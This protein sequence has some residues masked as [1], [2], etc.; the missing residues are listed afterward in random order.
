MAAPAAPRAAAA[1]APISQRPPPSQTRSAAIPA[2]A[3]PAL[4]PLDTVLAI[5]AA[6]VGLIAIGT[7]LW[8][9]FFVLK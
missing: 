2:P 7:T 5:A 6:V 4:S 1:P 8:L 3:A 9:A